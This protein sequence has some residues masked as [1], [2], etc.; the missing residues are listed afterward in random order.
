MWNGEARAE[1]VCWWALTTV[2]SILAYSLSGSSA[3]I[4]NRLSQTPF[5][6]HREDRL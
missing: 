2:A 3:K 1:R 5:S 6:A 4:L